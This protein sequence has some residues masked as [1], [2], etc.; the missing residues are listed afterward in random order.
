MYK[1]LQNIFGLYNTVCC[2]LYSGTQEYGCVSW[3]LMTVKKCPYLAALTG[4][5][6]IM[7]A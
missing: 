3:Q 2:I 7:E 6:P 1:T 4:M 5:Y